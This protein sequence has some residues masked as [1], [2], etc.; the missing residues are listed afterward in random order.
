M[1]DGLWYAGRGSFA[2]RIAQ[3][4]KVLPD[5]MATPVTG[6]AQWDWW[7]SKGVRPWGLLMLLLGQFGL[8]GL[9]LCFGALLMPALREA[10]RAPRASAWQPRGLPLMLATLVVLTVLDGLLN[11]F[12]FFPAVTAAGGL[13]AGGLR[14][15]GEITR[16]AS[17]S[18]A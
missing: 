13:A 2:W 10:W 17:R 14:P 4:Q 16:I 6:S 7:R 3:D 18:A 1:D 5:A 8:V 15:P 9:C 12:L 11:S